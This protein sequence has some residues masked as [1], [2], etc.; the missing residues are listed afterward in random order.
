MLLALKT[1]SEKLSTIHL[2]TLAK[3]SDLVKELEKYSADL[4]KKHKMI[5]DEESPTS[6]VVKSLQ[7][8]TIM[9]HKSKEFYKKYP[10]C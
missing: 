1:A 10:R 5:K 2:A 3:V 9:L 8:T 6:D 4:H 7:E